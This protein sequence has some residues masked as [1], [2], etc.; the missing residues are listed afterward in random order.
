MKLMKKHLLTNIIGL[1]LGISVGYFMLIGEQKGE[2]IN[3]FIVF[4]FAC[5]GA[6][7]GYVNL[8]VS[9]VLD[10]QLP[11][12]TNEGTRLFLGIILHFVIT[13]LVSVFILYFYLQLVNPISD[14]L[15]EY[16]LILIKLSIILFIISILFQV[17]Y[18]ALYS[19]YAYATLQIETIKLKRN[20]I[21]HQLEALKS[22]LSPHFLF[23]GLN[24]ISSL[25]HKDKTK[26]SLFIRKLAL[27][28]D[29]VLKSYDTKLTELEK[30]MELVTSYI[31]LINNRFENKFKCEITLSPVLSG[32]KIP[33]LSIQML[34]ENAVKHNVLSVEKPLMMKITNDEEFIYVQNNITSKPKNVSSF[35]IGLK[36]IN[37][38]YLLLTGK[39]IEM[40]NG[41][42]FLVKLP[43][44]R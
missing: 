38:R 33:P 16:S 43:I 7:C 3:T 31:F 22:Q 23:N 4:L 27:M 17:V 21:E 41:D 29:Y 8:F 36:N 18:F 32:T 14:F 39:N 44:I 25:T 42:K 11:W 6:V 20:Q 34:V 40:S 13:F 1:I 19:Y 28:Y 26:A 30:E 10:K 12:K 24:A 15:S 5:L 9:R 37:N 2:E 35:K